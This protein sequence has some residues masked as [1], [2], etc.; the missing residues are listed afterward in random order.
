MKFSKHFSV[1]FTVTVASPAVITTTAAHELYDGDSIELYTTGALPTGLSTSIIYYVVR[2]GITA[3]TFQVSLY[4]GGSSVITTGTQ[5]GTH[6]YIK[7][8]NASLK[9]AYEDNR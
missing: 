1:T 9:P 3:T 6:T 4:R 5:S 7:T 2:D 8:N